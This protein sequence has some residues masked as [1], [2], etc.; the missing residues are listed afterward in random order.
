MKPDRA[1]VQDIKLMS[2]PRDKTEVQQFPGL[3]TYLSRFIK[4]FSSK[5][6]VLSYLLHNDSEFLWEPHHQ[7]VFKD[8]KCEISEKYL[9]HY[10]YPKLPIYMRC[11]ASL[12]GIRRNPTS[13]WC[14]WQSGACR[15]CQQM[16]DTSRAKICMYRTRVT[17][18]CIWYT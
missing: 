1:K 8:L 18:H 7:R 14:I 3:M 12:Q 11:D 6:A 2:E 13:T 15:L 5:N 16:L 9:L 4:D 17:G 10:F